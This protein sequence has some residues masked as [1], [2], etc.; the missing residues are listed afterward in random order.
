MQQV[1]RASAVIDVHTVEFNVA[2]GFQVQ[3][4]GA[5]RIQLFKQ[6][7]GLKFAGID[8]TRAPG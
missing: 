1:C 6:F 2:G 3:H 7:V 8:H 5:K 4:L